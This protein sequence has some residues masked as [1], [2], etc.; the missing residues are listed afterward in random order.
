MPEHKSPP[1]TDISHTTEQELRHQVTELSVLHAVANAT[2]AGALNED[3]LIERVVEIVGES[4]YPDELGIFLL[5]SNDGLLHPHPS[6]RTKVAAMPIAIG[7]GIPGRVAQDGQPRRIPDVRESD[8]YYEVA[9]DTRSELCVPL[10]SGEKILGVLDVESQDVDAFS[11]ADEQ[12]LTTLAGQLAAAIDRLR[13]VQ[14]AKQHAQKISA[15]YR[16][17]RQITTWLSLHQLLPQTV[18]II[19]E[20][21][22]LDYVRLALT[23]DGTIHSCAERR[24]DGSTHFVPERDSPYPTT[25]VDQ[26]AAKGVPL[27]IPELSTTTLELPGPKSGALL[28]VPLTIQQEVIGILDVRSKQPYALTREDATLLEILAAQVTAAVRNAQLYEASQRRARELEGLYETALATSS[29]L[30]PTEL[31]RRLN[32]Q[33]QQLI[34]P[35]HF[36]MTLYDEKEAEISVVFSI[37]KGRTIPHTLDVHVPLS[38]GG[39]AGWVMQHRRSLLVDDLPGEELP[40]EPIHVEP[41]TRSWLGVPL[42]AHD[43]LV[44]ALSIQRK[45]RNAFNDFHRRFLE[46]LARQ[47]AIALANARLHR[48]ALETADRLAVLHWASQEIIS[49]SADPQEVCRAIH[50]ATSRLMESEAFVVALVNEENNAIDL[51]YLVDRSGRQPPQQIEADAGLSGHVIRTGRSLRT[52]DIQEI[53][54]ELGVVH[55]G[56]EEHVTSVLAVPLKLRDK[57]FGLLSAQSYKP[58]VYTQDDQRIL[59]MLASHAAIALENARLFRAERER[60]AELE[61]VRQASLQLTS[62]LELE[63]VLQAILKHA[64]KLVHADDAHVFLYDGQRLEFG[65]AR[66]ADGEQHKSW[67]LPRED[68]LTYTVARS[69]E[70]IVINDMSRHPL[71]KGTLWQGAIVGLPLLRGNEV[72][73]VMN[74]AYKKPYTLDENELRT[75]SLLADQA[76]VAIQNARLFAES[77][78]RT[79][80]LSEALARLRELDQLKSQFIQNTSHELRTP[81]TIIRGHTELLEQGE[82][83]PLEPKQA[84]SVTIIARRVRLLSKM[85]DDLTAILNTE[86]E[87]WQREPVDLVSLLESL[88]SEF[89]L[90]A[91][92]TGVRLDVDIRPSEAQVLGNVLHLRRVL[93][94][95]VDNAI[96]FTPA[97]GDV[98]VQL[99]HDE[100]HI[101]LRVIDTGIGIPESQ[102]TR[103]F[104]RFYQVD[105][106]MTRRY[107]GT[108]LGLALVKEIVEAHGGAVSVESTAGEGSTFHVT[109]PLLSSPAS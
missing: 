65:A 53:E 105:G 42:V 23:A 43:Q 100:K 67:A 38:Q 66:W 30:E 82:L 71:F 96:K 103:I 50:E 61:A 60:S 102:L 36:F 3:T 1:T 44:G 81:L 84:R 12:L 108:G 99:D 6:Y 92:Q 83:G 47:V 90:R 49:I 15:I 101:H 56:D 21:L 62:S 106:S 57:I 45:D 35:D 34:A 69:G 16:I 9:A 76:T 93:D 25:L 2:S 51:P 22:N 13:E 95:L 109:L 14:I 29:V 54:D 85:L 48:D 19:A 32:I 98:Q 39:L 18:Q 20:T 59:E 64:I 94:N 10:K 24:T 107:G 63:P 33:I 52:G 5:D 27:L 91:H 87:E 70:R 79:A 73:G 26:S 31:L 37:R 8:E 77:Q 28:I 74:I 40:V 4:L 41:G 58:D 11:E 17:G 75:L 7:E 89:K 97:G 68:G 86:T 80:E 104:D 88:V 72:I 78:R 46:S 55:F